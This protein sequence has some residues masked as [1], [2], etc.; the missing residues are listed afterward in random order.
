MRGSLSVFTEIL[1]LQ[2]WVVPALSAI[3]AGVAALL[4]VWLEETTTSLGLAIDVEPVSARALLS[5]VSSAM[6]SF[7][8]L[9]FTVTML[10]LQLASSQLSPRVM[11]TFLRD[12]FNQSVLGLFVATFIFSLLM[13]ASVKDDFVPQLGVIASIGLVLAAVLAFVAYIDHMAHAIRPTSVIGAIAAE[14]RDAIDRNY[15]ALDDA[16]VDAEADPQAPPERVDDA[17]AGRTIRW[18]RA[19]GYIQAIDE[20]RLLEHAAGQGDRLR[21]LA[22]IGEYIVRDAPI[23]ALD[24]GD[25]AADTVAAEGLS[26]AIRVGPERTM[27]QDPGFGFRQLVDVALR[28]L[29]PSLNDPTTANQVIDQL[30]DLL[31]HL[32]TREIAAPRRVR[33]EAGASIVIP[34]PDWDAFVVSAVDEIHDASASMPQVRTHLRAMLAS[35]T[36]AASPGRQPAVRRALARFD[37]DSAS[38]RA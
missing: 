27:S 16:E 13:L 21:L 2:I 19:S 7:T 11:R 32:L 33:N 37:S 10:V 22:G 31:R 15:A 34:A 3:L 4:V 12:R 35:L 30:H 28:A 6:I 24:D 9:V 26:D 18:A 25:G 1:R 8:G 14:T 29:S 23:L 20:E 36:D 17:E 5:A 38:E